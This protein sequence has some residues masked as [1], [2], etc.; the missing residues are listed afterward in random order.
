MENFKENNT[1]FMA[2]C[3]TKYEYASGT[4][5]QLEHV[6]AFGYNYNKTKI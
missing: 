4:T 6:A 5:G 3:S 1:M 2:T